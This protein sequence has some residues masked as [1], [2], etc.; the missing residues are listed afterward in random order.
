[1]KKQ[2]ASLIM[3]IITFTAF[4]QHKKLSEIIR[5][6]LNINLFYNPTGE[7]VYLLNQDAS[8]LETSENKLGATVSLMW[9]IPI[10][11]EGTAN[12]ILNIPIV[13]LKSNVSDIKISNGLF[14]TQTPFG[15]GFGVFPFPEFQ[16]LGFSIIVNYSAQNK[17]RAKPLK[18]NYF[19]ISDYPTFDL[20]VGAPVPEAVLKP[21]LKK[22]SLAT[23]NVGIVFR[24]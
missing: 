7:Y 15:L 2:M 16:T 23:V 13:D 19:P 9:L 8:L 1:M 24:L 18:E 6:G 17:M 5:P 12:V 14:N 11:E 22:E 20:K 21:F 10:N 3:L 4:S